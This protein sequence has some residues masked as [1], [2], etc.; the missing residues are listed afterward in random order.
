MLLKWISLRIASPIK[1]DRRFDPIGVPSTSAKNNI[2]GRIQA[3]TTTTTATV[4]PTTTTGSG[5]NK[6][7]SSTGQSPALNETRG[8]KVKRTAPQNPTTGAP[9]PP[10]RQKA[11][12]IKEKVPP[13]VPPRG[14]PRSTGGSSGNI[15]HRQHNQSHS[16]VRSSKDSL[17]DAG[18]KRR[19]EEDGGELFV[20]QFN[21]KLRWENPLSFVGLFPDINF[22]LLIILSSFSGGPSGCSTPPPPFDD[23]SEHGSTSRRHYDDIPGSSSRTPNNI[24]ASHY[25]H[26]TSSSREDSIRWVNRFC[27]L[28]LPSRKSISIMSC[29]V[30]LKTLSFYY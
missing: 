23:I 5:A 19:P 25:S 16:S 15:S 11:V 21:F 18:W 3:N 9:M 20:W 1:A 24:S 14:S 4:A 6:P 8:G 2:F 7:L 26:T 27:P 28:D 22:G 12:V 17:K 10:L 29:C 30:C 13:P